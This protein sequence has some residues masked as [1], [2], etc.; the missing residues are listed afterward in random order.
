MGHVLPAEPLT[1][2]ILFRKKSSITVLLS[3][4]LLFVI[5]SCN[6]RFEPPSAEE[7]KAF[8]SRHREDIDII[9][10]YLKELEYD[11]AFIDVDKDSGRIFYEF[12]WHEIP[13]VNV[14]NSIYRL[15]ISGCC[16][17]SKDAKQEINT[18][19][20]MI[21]TRTMGSVDCGIA[22]TMNGQGK[23]KTEFQVSCEEIGDGWF[24]YYDDYEE[25]RTLG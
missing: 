1:Y 20:F 11:S 7:A 15:R 4:A 14:K 23:P 24:Y 8:L 5:V 6:F 12:D 25:Y 9:V 21:W 17:I 10:N 16:Q 13:S 2:M 19:S 18:I 22:C 3:V